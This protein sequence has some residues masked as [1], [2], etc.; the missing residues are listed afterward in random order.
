MQRPHQFTLVVNWL[1]TYSATYNKSL[2]CVLSGLRSSSKTQDV[3]DNERVIGRRSVRRPAGA[4]HLLLHQASQ[5]STSSTSTTVAD[6][7]VAVAGRARH[8]QRYAW[9]RCTDVRVVREM[10]SAAPCRRAASRVAER[11]VG[12]GERGG[13]GDVVGGGRC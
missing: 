9:I 6:F 8:H 3:S 13:R 5:S 1:F 4:V 10:L 7:V 2:R 12:E 11:V